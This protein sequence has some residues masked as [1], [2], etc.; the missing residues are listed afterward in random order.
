ML[1]VG[2]RPTALGPG[3]PGTGPQ[4]NQSQPST[5]PTAVLA[6]LAPAAGAPLTSQAVLPPEDATA[7]TEIAERRLP[8]ELI[9]PQP[10]E[11]DEWSAGN[12][13]LQVV[14]EPAGPL[15]T[16]AQIPTEV[17]QEISRLREEAAQSNILGVRGRNDPTPM[18]ASADAIGAQSG[19]ARVPYDAA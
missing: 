8:P 2:L 14:T 19:L 9:A 6:G 16:F 4:Q 3:E 15:K 10:P 12:P 11:G 1:T 13:V 7:P 17:M 18:P 5:S